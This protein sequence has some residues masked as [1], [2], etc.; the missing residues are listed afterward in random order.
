MT[1][2]DLYALHALIGAALDDI[3]RIYRDASSSPSPTPT[4]PYTDLTSPCTPYRRRP[5]R[6]TSLEDETDEEAF[7]LP[8]L[9]TPK[10]PRRPRHS[11]SLDSIDTVL[12]FPPL[13]K[14]YYPTEAHDANVE[15][16]ESL[17]SHP[18]VIA[19]ANRIVAACGQ[20][21]ATVHR[22]FLTLNDAAMGVRPLFWPPPCVL[23]AHRILL[24]VSL[25]CLSSL[26][27]RMHLS[28]AVT[29]RRT[30]RSKNGSNQSDRVV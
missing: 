4:T 13:D 12:D 26:P 24:S 21:S 15:A 6:R 5:P 17:A 25:T 18:D 27:G 29:L 10:T 7:P 20:I 9:H 19:A 11:A 2:A 28:F 16:A 8:P 30:P 14:P 1:L 23:I 22:P 3:E